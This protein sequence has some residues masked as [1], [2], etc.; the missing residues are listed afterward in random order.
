LQG[1]VRHIYVTAPGDG[2]RVLAASEA[3]ADATTGM[4]L[5]SAAAGGD[6]AKGL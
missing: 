2:P 5:A 4:P 6:F 3:L 1:A